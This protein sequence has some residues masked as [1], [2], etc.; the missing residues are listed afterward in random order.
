MLLLPKGINSAVKKLPKLEIICN[1]IHPQ[2]PAK[3]DRAGKRFVCGHCG[4]NGDADYNGSKN[5]A[6]LGVLVNAPEGSEML[7]CSLSKH[8]ER[9]VES[10]TLAHE[11]TARLC[12]VG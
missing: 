4:W 11:R 10:S 1:H 8:I 5:I 3:S 9:A 2:Y 12:R 7:S 6:A